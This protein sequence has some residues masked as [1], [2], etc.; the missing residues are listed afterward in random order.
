MEAFGLTKK[1]VLLWPRE[2][3]IILY[4]Y[5]G[6]DPEGFKSDVQAIKI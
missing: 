5:D 3:S 1:S 4:S 2:C 6:T